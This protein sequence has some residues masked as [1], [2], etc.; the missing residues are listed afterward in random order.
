MLQLIVF[1]FLLD[2]KETKNQDLF[3]H[4]ALVKKKCFAT[5]PKP[6]GQLLRKVGLARGPLTHAS[7]THFFLTIACGTEIGRSLISLALKGKIQEALI[8]VFI[9]N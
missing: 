8:A 4:L 7:R 9:H 6:Q 2:Q 1:F 3:Q 5:Q